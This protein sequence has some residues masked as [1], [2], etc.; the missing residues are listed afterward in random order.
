MQEL[1][2]LSLLLCLLPTFLSFEESIV[3]YKRILFARIPYFLNAL[4][5]LVIYLIL[6]LILE[7]HLSALFS[8][9]V[10]FLPSLSPLG[11]AQMEFIQVNVYIMHDI[12]IENFKDVLK[13]NNGSESP[14]SRL[15]ISKTCVVK[16]ILCC[17]WEWHRPQSRPW[18]AFCARSYKFTHNRTTA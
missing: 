7:M 3:T 6:A 1:N 16:C 14:L 10:T 18:I 8:S 5:S 12:A 17:W 4:P 15:C 11:F 13:C 2:F 9:S